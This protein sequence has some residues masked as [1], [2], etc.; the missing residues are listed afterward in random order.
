MQLN[1]EAA[2]EEEAALAT[3]QPPEEEAERTRLA[4]EAD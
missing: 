1:A 2:D 3:D 4:A